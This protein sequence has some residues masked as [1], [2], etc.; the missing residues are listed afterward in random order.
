M[1]E[2]QIQRYLDGTLSPAEAQELHAHKTVCAQCGAVMAQ[3]MAADAALRQARVGLP[4]PGDLYAGFAQKLAVER[5][6]RGR[7]PFAMVGTAAL[8][9]AAATSVLLYLGYR[10][11]HVPESAA[12]PMVA[13]VPAPQLQSPVMSV[14]P[15]E[16]GSANYAGSASI[17]TTRRAKSVASTPAIKLSPHGAMAGE[18]RERMHVAQ[19]YSLY[20]Q[21]QSTDGM[22]A[23]KPE[24]RAPAMGV[25]LPPNSDSVAK[26]PL[27]AAGLALAANNAANGQFAMQVQDDVRGFTAEVSGTIA[28]VTGAPAR[29]GAGADVLV[30]VQRDTDN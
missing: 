23:A 30:E 1:R 21:P 5:S 13:A 8:G 28:A 24:P 20:S 2:G 12:M 19:R 18:K 26:M 3:E 25:A 11:Q 16:A 6:H 29:N 7:S 22:N 10:P 17:V 4:E 9:L 15:A 27:A 14:H